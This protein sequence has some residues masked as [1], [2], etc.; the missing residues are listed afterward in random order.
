MRP[1]ATAL[2]ATVLALALTAGP[3]AAQEATQTVQDSALAGQVG[4]V[5]VNAP[6]RVASDGD[7]EALSASVGGPQTATG[8]EGSA[9][10]ARSA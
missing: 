3:A 8:S 1:S 4:P 7:N 10:A 6:V 5:Q 2:W 9:Q